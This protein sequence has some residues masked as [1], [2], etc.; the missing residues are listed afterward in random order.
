MPNIE[1]T[2][3]DKTPTKIEDKSLDIEKRKT[4]EVEKDLD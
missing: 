1:V 2:N 4:A 3:E